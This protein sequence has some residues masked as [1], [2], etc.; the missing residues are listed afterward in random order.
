MFLTFKIKSKGYNY[1]G[2]AEVTNF[3]TSDATILFSQNTKSSSLFLLACY[4]K[5]QYTKLDRLVDSLC[6]ENSLQ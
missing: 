4:E 2:K 6:N 5:E 1:Q 3:A